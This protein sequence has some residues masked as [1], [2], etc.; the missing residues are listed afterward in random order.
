MFSLWT[1]C[2]FTSVF[3]VTVEE[4]PALLSVLTNSSD[5][6]VIQVELSGFDL[7]TDEDISVVFAGW[8]SG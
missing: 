6:S 7:R 4:V 8:R 5:D 1:S 3:V 2:L